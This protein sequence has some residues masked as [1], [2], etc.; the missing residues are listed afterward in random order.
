M[1]A[2]AQPYK[3]T[4]NTGLGQVRMKGRVLKVVEGGRVE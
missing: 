3:K 4:T 2:P 1:P